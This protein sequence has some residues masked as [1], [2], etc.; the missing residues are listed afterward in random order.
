LHKFLCIQ[1]GG[2]WLFDAI[3]TNVHLGFLGSYLWILGG[4]GYIVSHLP[5]TTLNA[6]ETGVHCLVGR[7]PD[8]AV[9]FT[10][11]SNMRSGVTWLCG[12]PDPHDSRAK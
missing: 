7:Q 3:P 4:E 11:I 9:P 6:V 10:S 1:Q 8:T 5:L 2:I 12:N